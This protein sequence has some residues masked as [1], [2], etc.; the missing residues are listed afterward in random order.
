M[1]KETHAHARFE[2][3]GVKMKVDITGSVKQIAEMLCSAML[4]DK[5]VEDMIKGATMLYFLEQFPKGQADIE[6]KFDELLKTASKY[7]A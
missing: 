6:N 3:D 4:K 1:Q 5:D 7:Q 2:L